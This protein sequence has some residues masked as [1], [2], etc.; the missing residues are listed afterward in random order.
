MR[1]L[2]LII[3]IT[4]IVLI[5]SFFALNTYI[6]NEKQAAPSEEIKPYRGTLSG[7]YVCLPHT[8]QNGPQTLECAFGI[9]TTS[10][11][12]YAVDFNLMSQTPPE[13][14]AGDK[15]TANGTITPIEML[16]TDHWKKYP[17]KGIFSITDSVEKQN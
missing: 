5:A 16:S 1:K 11:E 14:K 3:S 15:F 8:N 6:Y 9:K 7:E 13:L 4:F 2:L 12:Y 17:I 10:G